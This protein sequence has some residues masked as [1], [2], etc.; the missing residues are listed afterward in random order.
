M[1]RR[2]NARRSGQVSKRR[3]A[4]RDV[5]VGAKAPR[6]RPE[7]EE[8]VQPSGRCEGRP[9]GKLRFVGE[10][11]ADA[12]LAQAQRRRSW[13]NNPHA[14]KRHYLCPKCSTLD[15]PAYH[16]TSVDYNGRDDG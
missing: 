14:E 8:M 11:V 4:S 16:L 2:N 10:D 9:D 13:Q 7:L 3:V 12:A 5:T 1:P 6:W 15:E